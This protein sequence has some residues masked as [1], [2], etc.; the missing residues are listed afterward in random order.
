MSFKDLRHQLEERNSPSKITRLFKGK[1]VLQSHNPANIGAM[2][3]GVKSERRIKGVVQS[4]FDHIP[5]QN[6]TYVKRVYPC[7]IF[8]LFKVSQRVMSGN[9]GKELKNM[10]SSQ[11]GFFNNDEKIL[12]LALFDLCKNGDLKEHQNV[13]PEIC[14]ITWNNPS[15]IMFCDGVKNLTPEDCENILL[16][17]QGLSGL[18]QSYKALLK[19]LVQSLDFDKKDRQAIAQL[20]RDFIDNFATPSHVLINLF[21]EFSKSQETIDQAIHSAK[22]IKNPA[23]RSRSLNCIVTNLMGSRLEEEAFSFVSSLQGTT[24]F[25]KC[26]SAYLEELLFKNR[27]ESHE[28]IEKIHDQLFQ[29]ASSTEDQTEREKIYQQM[30]LGLAKQGFIG[31]GVETALMINDFDMQTFTLSTI[32][33]TLCAR[34]LFREAIPICEFINEPSFKQDAHSYIVKGL[35][36]D[37]DVEGAVQFVEHLY[38]PIERTKAAKILL[39]GLTA[40]ANIQKI[41]KSEVAKAQQKFSLGVPLKLG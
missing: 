26:L 37:D 22:N 36:D 8:C 38:D 17:K 29:L 15:L 21:F 1:T 9:Y 28:L 10:A 31:E 39:S 4:Y 32:V 40:L 11:E 6:L 16:G 3:R 13:F 34:Q 35:L 19:D 12:E 23:E 41:D 20:F 27:K 30:A 14:S 18:F 5:V 2:V 7:F 33:N 24:E 25:P